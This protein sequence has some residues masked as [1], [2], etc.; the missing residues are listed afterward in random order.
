M[1]FWGRIWKHTV[2]E[3]TNRFF[4]VCSLSFQ[5]AFFL[6]LFNADIGRNNRIYSPVVFHNTRFKNLVTG[7]NCHIGRDCFLDLS[8]VIRLED[9]VTISMRT[10]LIT[11]FDAGDSI[12]NTQQYEP[13]KKGITIKE[14]SYLGANVTV[15]AGVTIGCNCIVAAGS[16]VTKNI[17]DNSLCAGVPCKEIRS[18]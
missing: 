11:H 2:L 3:G 17:K 16:V 1:T 18:L 8:D 6:R 5:N 15:L 10:T 12:N 14:G 4:R 9:N 13:Y 7:D